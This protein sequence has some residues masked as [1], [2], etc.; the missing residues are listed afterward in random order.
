MR[1]EAF[2]SLVNRRVELGWPLRQWHVLLQAKLDE[3]GYVHVTLTAMPPD[4]YTGK[5]GGPLVLQSMQA[6]EF[7]ELMNEQQACEWIRSLVLNFVTHEVAE[8]FRLDGQR[9]FDPHD[10]PSRPWEERKGKPYSGW[11]EGPTEP[12]IP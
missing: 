1:A 11:Y 6:P 3:F 10:L 7:I 5:P 12:V 8:S 4:S 2:L 9:V